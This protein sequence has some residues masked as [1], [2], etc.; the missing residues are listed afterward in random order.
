MKSERTMLV[1]AHT[2]RPAGVR[3]ARLV[4]HRLSAAGVAVRVLEPEAADL[5]P[6]PAEVVPVSERAASDADVCE[7]EM[8]DPAGDV[9]ADRVGHGAPAHKREEVRARAGD[10]QAGP[11]GAEAGQHQ[12]RRERRETDEHRQRG[13]ER[14]GWGIERDA[15]VG[16]SECGRLP[17]DIDDGDAGD[18][19][20]S[21]RHTPPAHT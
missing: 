16:R 18:D 19:G 10:D 12:R 3:V 8:Q 7:V 14:R 13:S 15:R 9:D 2:G 5:G 17:A 21:K 20:R 11:R 1:V 4:M 6:G